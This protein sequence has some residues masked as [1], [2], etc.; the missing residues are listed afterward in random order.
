[1]V[2]RRTPERSG[3][4]NLPPLCCA[5]EQ[6]TLLVLPRKQWL[7]PEMTEKLLAGTLNLK[8]DN[9]TNIQRNKLLLHK[10]I[11]PYRRCAVA[12][13]WACKCGNLNK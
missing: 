13:C 10:T 3:V 2:E 6:D 11:A 5:P 4:R 9:K 12:F 1:M 8:T 7:R